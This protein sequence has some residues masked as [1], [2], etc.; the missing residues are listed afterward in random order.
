MGA[1]NNS[2]DDVNILINGNFIDLYTTGNLIDPGPNYNFDFVFDNNFKISKIS[3]FGSY[4][5]EL[6]DLPTGFNIWNLS[7]Q[8]A[9]SFLNIANITS[10]DYN[11]NF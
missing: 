6:I 11:L 9:I 7:K 2:T 8:P 3:I 4:N 1:N 10:F 5:E